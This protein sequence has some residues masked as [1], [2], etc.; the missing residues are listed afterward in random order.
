MDTYCLTKESCHE[1]LASGTFLHASAEALMMKSFTEIFF[2]AFDSKLFRSL[3]NLQIQERKNI[4]II[5][6]I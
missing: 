4:I 1:E 6:V 5:M 3:R 2:P